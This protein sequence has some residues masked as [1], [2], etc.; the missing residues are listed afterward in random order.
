M[1]NKKGTFFGV[2]III[3][4]ITYIAFFGLTIGSLHIKGSNELRYG[5]DIRGGVE[6]VYEPKDLGRV[7]TGDEL[8]AARAILETRLDAKNIT[9]REVTVDK[10]NGQI[11]VRFPWKSDEAT[12]NPQ[13]AIAELGQTAKLTFRDSQ[14][15]VLVEG[16]EVTKS[17]PKLNQQTNK[18]EVD[19]TFSDKGSQQFSD[20]TGKLVGQQMGIFMDEKLISAPKVNEKISGGSASITGIESFDEAKALSDN[21][22]SGALPFSLISKNYSTISPTLGAGALSVMEK[23]MLTAAILVCLF[24]MLFYRVPGFV[25]C[26]GMLL[27]LSAQILF[28][29]VPQYTLTLPG[30]AGIILSIGMG[31]DTNIIIAERIKEEIR[32]GKTLGGAIDLGYHRAFT[33][34]LDGHVT[35]IIVAVVLMIFGSGAMLSFGYTLLVGNLMNFVSGIIASR[36]MTTSLSQYKPLRRTTLYG[37]RRVTQ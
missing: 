32:N 9:D 16:A 35:T 11:L 29:S 24:M 4:L 30:I 33:A 5:I 25:A 21:I 18:P 28:L 2:V 7:P 1:R 19:L 36:L 10:N 26:I 13:T 14:G 3:A 27:E 20:A 12:F 23:A 22:N 8:E 6:A 15:N 17:S 31:V 34:I 37:D